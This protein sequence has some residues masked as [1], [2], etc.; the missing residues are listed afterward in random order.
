MA[1]KK[2][3]IAFWIVFSTASLVFYAVMR[4]IVEPILVMVVFNGLFK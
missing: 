1:E 3:S 4:F 2:D